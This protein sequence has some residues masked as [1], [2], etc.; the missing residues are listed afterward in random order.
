[1]LGERWVVIA[2]LSFFGVFKF[3]VMGVMSVVKSNNKSLFLLFLMLIGQQFFTRASEQ[4]S[5]K[6]MQYI[7]LSMYML[8]NY[9]AVDCEDQKIID[10]FNLLQKETGIYIDNPLFVCKKT[11]QNIDKLE[12]N[13][14]YDPSY[15]VVFIVASNFYKMSELAQKYTL[16]HELRHHQQFSENAYDREISETVQ[17]YC[18]Q[19]SITYKQAKEYDADMFAI[20]HVCK[21]CPY[22]LKELRRD[23]S[24]AFLFWRQHNKHGYFSWDDYQKVLDEIVKNPVCCARHSNKKGKRNFYIRESIHQIKPILYMTTTRLMNIALRPLVFM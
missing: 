19:K 7:G 16:A 11:P 24:L 5:A 9:S 15:Q 8:N 6:R 22:C 3:C 2:E 4:I 21:K 12:Y 20:Q 10:M 1:M 14:A 23:N 13:A 17:K 18:Q